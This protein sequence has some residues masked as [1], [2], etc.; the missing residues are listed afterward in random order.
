MK[1]YILKPLNN[2]TTEK[3]TKVVAVIIVGEL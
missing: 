1:N 2:L 3:I